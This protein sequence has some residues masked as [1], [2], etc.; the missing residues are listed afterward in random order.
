MADYLSKKDWRTHLKLKEHKSIKK[1]G[2]SDTLS[3]Y[4]K[5]LKKKDLAGQVAALEAII[6]KVKEVK[7]KH[8]GVR[9]LTS[10]LDSM[11]KEAKTAQDKIQDE[12]ESD[13]GDED[14]S[15]K[16]ALAKMLDRA[17]Q[18]K[19]DNP[20]QF[21]IA[22]GKP[23]CGLVMHKKKI[24]KKHIKEAIAMRGKAGRFMQGSC[25]F[26]K[27][28]HV[29]DLGPDAKAPQSLAKSIKLAA[30]LHAEKTIKV[31]VRG[32]GLEFDDE[33]DDDR[34][35][36]GEA[37]TRSGGASDYP[38]LARW[39]KMLDTLRKAKPADRDGVYSGIA[40]LAQRYKTQAAQDDA[41][42]DAEKQ[43]QDTLLDGVLQ[44]AG[45]VINPDPAP[46]VPTRYPSPEDWD[47]LIEKVG[48]V[49]TAKRKAA[50]DKV[51]EQ[52]K[53]VRAEIAADAGLSAAGKK[54][55]TKAWK[56]ALAKVD[57]AHRDL[58]K[59]ATT[60]SASG[61][62]KRFKAL[63]RRFDTVM[64]DD[65]PPSTRRSLE[66]L[67]D[68]VKTALKAKD[69]DGAEAGMDSLEDD[70]AEAQEAANAAKKAELKLAEQ[71]RLH[72]TMAPSMELATKASF[73]AGNA[74][75][76]QSK[77]KDLV[78]KDKGFAGLLKAMEAC[79][80]NQDEA[81]MRGLAEQASTYL[82]TVEAGKPVLGQNANAKATAAFQKDLATFEKKVEIAKVTVQHARLAELA[83][84]YTALGSPPWDEA[85]SEAAAELRASYFFEESA[86]KSGGAVRPAAALAD[87]GVNESW[88]I[89]RIEEGYLPVGETANA[90]TLR[91]GQAAQVANKHKDAVKNDKTFA[92]VIKH[93]S[94]FE[95]DRT[96]L[97]LKAL[98]AACEDYL[99]GVGAE[100]AALGDPPDATA[101]G[102]IE[103]RETFVKA[104]RKEAS[105]KPKRHCIFKPGGLETN[106][107]AGMP[108]GS[109]AP[110]EVLAKKLSDEMAAAGFEIG[111]CP[112]SLISVDLAKL[113]EAEERGANNG[114]HLGAM[115]ELAAGHDGAL[116]D[117]L[118]S[119]PAFC[120]KI[121]PKNYGELA[122]F[123]MMFGNLD[124]HPGNFMAGE[125][126]PET[127][128][129]KLIPI[130][131]GFGLPSPEVMT[132]NRTRMLGMQN[133]LLRDDMPQKDKPL[134]PEVIDCLEALDPAQLIAAMKG[135]RDGMAGRHPEAA[136]MVEDAAIE[137]IGQRLA[138]IKAAA[139]KLTVKELFQAQGIFG[140]EIQDADPAD[141]NDL[142]KEIKKRLKAQDEGKEAINNW[143]GVAISQGTP[144]EY[145]VLIDLGWLYDMGLRDIMF[146]MEANAAL[147]IKIARGNIPNPAALAEIDERKAL[148][149]DPDINDELEGLT[150]KEQVQLL[151]RRAP[152]DWEKG[153]R[154][155][156]QSELGTTYERL[157]GDAAWQA[158]IR[159]FPACADAEEI[160]D[161]VDF[162]MQWK[163]FNDAGGMAEYTR[164]G[165]E[166]L[167]LLSEYVGRLIMLKGSESKRDEIEA[168]SDSAVL[169]R[170]RQDI[171]DLN[172]QARAMIKSVAS[173][174]KRDAFL[175]EIRDA[176][177]LARAG[178]LDEVQ[179]RVGVTVQRMKALLAKQDSERATYTKRI[180]DLRKKLA[181][182]GGQAAADF[183]DDFEA[184]A[185]EIHAKL[186]DGD[187]SAAIRVHR[188]MRAE[189]DRAIL[190][191]D[192]EVAKWEKSVA[193][194]RAIIASARGEFYE[195]TLRDWLT[196]AES[197][198]DSYDWGSID[199]PLK[200]IDVVTQALADWPAISAALDRLAE[201]PKYDALVADH[202][203][204]V[205]KLSRSAGNS[206]ENLVSDLRSKVEAAQREN[207]A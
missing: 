187:F 196:S 200:R 4:E 140:A 189:L 24:Q 77:Y 44:Q 156:D 80:K 153:A 101:L 106:E 95:K 8:S 152:R 114:R 194:A 89:E 75:T 16:G 52:I 33:D 28:K 176:V 55:E 119:D 1:T 3:P 149:N 109:G 188:E 39:T 127:G 70:I 61:H 81:A 10:Y 132:M 30:K 97:T 66:S 49:D 90:G 12:L 62:L 36:A 144:A 51:A 165:G 82:K 206:I 195:P 133:S 104:T 60:I 178:K 14:D 43:A 108:P 130:D 11:A 38:D 87:G 67:M 168:L 21:V 48:R 99:R 25:Y 202:N 155:I 160:E 92:L 163:A 37:K 174:E 135:S 147:A 54:R 46:P 113:Q 68:Q 186:D 118:Q 94:A 128:Q 146:W 93:L 65:L 190:G 191:D 2:I 136:G 170:Q 29:F 166:Q 148:L 6:A 134:D 32:G 17:R 18:R 207:A 73:P 5:A 172:A 26:D 126:D 171:K 167:P 192:S 162:L 56:D 91:P 157:G 179:A 177:D 83:A 40:G 103:E 204:I 85:K 59:L 182:A 175:D 164:L 110:R 181:N 185:D 199:W 129:V 137:G 84:Q 9:T 201:H 145:A 158:L 53:K 31:I 122:V 69:D 150:I 86:L 22:P 159:T 139:G 35:E 98:S 131:H 57:A 15:G 41:L 88:W 121:D 78:K 173:K 123:D 184:F 115:Q 161:K 125:E 112:T 107:F 45:K 151:R 120:Q 7:A 23:M 58:A 198:L 50:L 138:F 72:E 116:A 203:A 124:R 34:A 154:D 102:E 79:E 142:I 193:G 27:G 100:K 19:V 205:D 180:A 63:E 183:A 42:D 71:S 13:D 143:T 169:K 111:V 76:L 141:F 64:K 96:G 197:K 74:K 20:F 117:K 47:A 105:L